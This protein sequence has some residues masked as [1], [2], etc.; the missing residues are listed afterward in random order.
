MKQECNRCHK[1]KPVEDFNWRWKNL[2]VRQRTCRECQ[3]EQKNNWYEKN[4][5]THKANMYQNK[6]GKIEE[7][8]AYITEYLSTHPCVD[9]GESDLLVL[10]FDHVRG[11]KK[12][13][14]MMLVRAGYSV[15]VIQREISKCVVRCA[16]C[17][18]RK[19]YKGSWRG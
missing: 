2:G 11:N 7:S 16:N 14:V 4:K 15:D 1:V 13:T 9:C 12:S 17:H 6:L 10:E 3:K 8:R 19:T 5:E 18:K